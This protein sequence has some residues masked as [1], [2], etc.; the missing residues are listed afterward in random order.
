MDQGRMSLF[1]FSRKT[2]LKLNF[3]LTLDRS[4]IFLFSQ[5]ITYKK[6]LQMLFGVRMLFFGSFLT[7]KKDVIH[8]FNY[9]SS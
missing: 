4:L 3:R 9:G 2:S 1:L 5:N 8:N 6:D 7:H